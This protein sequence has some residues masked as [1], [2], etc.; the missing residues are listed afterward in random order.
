MAISFDMTSYRVDVIQETKHSIAGVTPCDISQHLVLTN[1]SDG[2]S[3]K[4]MPPSM[5][6]IDLDQF[7]RRMDNETK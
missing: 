4:S 7:L 3:L 6:N 5:S 1:N 2:K